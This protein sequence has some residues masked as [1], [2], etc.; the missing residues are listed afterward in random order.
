M[1][2]L[3]SLMS[4]YRDCAA[5]QEPLADGQHYALFGNINDIYSTSLW[6][7]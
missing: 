4:N 7:V 5:M 1:K 3:E 2:Q 6:S